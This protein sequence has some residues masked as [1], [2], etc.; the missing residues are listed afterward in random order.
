MDTILE[1]QLPIMLFLQKIQNGV[2]DAIAE[3]ITIMGEAFIPILIICWI[4]W[5]W[6]KKKGFGIISAMLSATVFMQVIKSI[7]RVPRPFMKYP[8]LITGKRVSTATG[9]SFPS[10][11]ST[12]SGSFYGALAKYFRKYK[13]IFA[14][15]IA[16][17]C[18]VPIS[19]LYL[20]VHWP[21]DV[22][23][24]TAIGLSSAFA[25]TI[26]FDFLYER[27]RAYIIFTMTCGTVLFAVAVILASLLDWAP[28]L[29]DKRA[30]GDFM[31]NTALAGGAFLGFSFERPM[32]KFKVAKTAGKR[33]LTYLLGLLFG[34]LIGGIL[35][36][37]VP[38][39]I[40][41]AKYLFEFLG[42]CFLGVWI[43][44]LW[45]LFAVKFGWMEQDTPTVEGM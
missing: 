9:Y 29:M 4:Y 3:I 8:D 43:S 18:L 1:F 39:F 34:I 25:L 27:E 40:P 33:A 35:L 36:F 12:T 21:L 11:H 42:Y 30:F 15:S 23:V 13:W 20:G 41:T 37:L 6:D 22:I 5:C 24:G 14:I 16:L 19:R 31:T 32:L 2:L 7:M 28:S 44:Y 38:Y 26:L 45:P 10:G 17:I